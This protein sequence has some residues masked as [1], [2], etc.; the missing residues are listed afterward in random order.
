MGPQVVSNPYGIIINNIFSLETMYA[1]HMIVL[2]RTGSSVWNEKNLFCGWYDSKLT[3]K[4]ILNALIAGKRLKKS[5]LD[6]FDVAYTSTM[7]RAQTTLKI[8]L[9]KLGK[10]EV[11]TVKTWRLNGRHWGALTGLN[12]T[13][14]VAKYGSFI[15]LEVQVIDSYNNRL[16]AMV[17]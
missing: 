4:G 11:K 17:W 16:L 8:I 14:A 2:I 10:P 6:F 7:S 9:S 12:F 5:G 13:E 1:K 15:A 3:A